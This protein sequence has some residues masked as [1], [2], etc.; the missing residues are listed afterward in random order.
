MLVA[1]CIKN[2]TNSL[3]KIKFNFNVCED[4]LLLKRKGGRVYLIC[5]NDVIYKVGY[6]IDK[7]S[8]NG[9]LNFY[10]GPMEGKPTQEVLA[11]IF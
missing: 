11:Y 4:K 8:I 9:T 10:E 6:S 1:K 5:V 7:N 3:A 2:P